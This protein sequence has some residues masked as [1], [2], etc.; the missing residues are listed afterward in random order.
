MTAVSVVIPTFNRAGLVPDAVRSVLGQGH[1][2]LECL[3]VDDGSTDGTLRVLEAVGDNRLRIIRQGRRGVSAARNRGLA[4]ARGE[5]LALLDSDDYW[6]PEKLTRQLAFMAATGHEI[7]QTNEI[8]LRRGR[9]VNPGARHEKP[10]GACF[11]RSLDLCCVSPSC[12]MFTRRLWEEVG[13]FDE[14]L[15]A[16]EDYDLWLRV[17]LGHRVGLLDQALVVRRGGRPDQLSASVGCL[18]IYRAYAILKAHGS[19]CLDPDQGRAALLELEKKA[20]IYVEGCRKRGRRGEADRV[21]NLICM[22]LA[23]RA[24]P[25]ESLLPPTPWPEPGDRGRGPVSA[26]ENP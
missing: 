18:D 21:W 9:R 20:R 6:L 7:S 16:C 13:P 24:V 23:G 19:G 26:Q 2:D 5:V 25:A 8:W 17:C 3:V 12:A 14:R 22:A 15:P 10:D 11:E 4:E 1:A